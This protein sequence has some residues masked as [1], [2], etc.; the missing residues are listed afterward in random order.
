MSFHRSGRGISRQIPR[1]S[2]LANNRSICTSRPSLNKSSSNIEN[3]AN[4]TEN[5]NFKAPISDINFSEMFQVQ[6]LSKKTISIP[7]TESAALIYAVDYSKKKIWNKF[8]DFQKAEKSVHKQLP[9]RVW[10]DIFRYYFGAKDSPAQ[11]WEKYTTLIR[12]MINSGIELTAFEIALV[13][14]VAALNGRH[15]TIREFWEAFGKTK[16]NRT[17]FLWNMYMEVTCNTNPKFWRRK[18]N[19]SISKLEL[20]PPVSNDAI[21][22]VSGIIADGLT[23][24]IL[25]YENVL[26]YLGQH[27]ELDYAE[28]LLSSLWKI[29]LENSPIEDEEDS[30]SGAV[31]KNSAIY[32]RI[33]TLTAIINTYGVNDQLAKGLQIVQKMREL[34]GIELNKSNSIKFWETVLGWAFN[35]K[36]PHGSISNTTFDTLWTGITKGHNIKPSD[37]L[38]YYKAKHERSKQNFDA[39]LETIPLLSHRKAGSIFFQTV[40]SMAKHGQIPKALDTIQIY[41]ERYPYL[42]ANGRAAYLKIHRSKQ[43]DKLSSSLTQPTTVDETA[44]AQNKQETES[45]LTPFNTIALVR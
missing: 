9:R 29:K 45:N 40:I 4:N 28:G 2:N 5:S 32:P 11:T 22:L 27:G 43:I 30:F 1:I 21:K 3:E 6:P 33:Q 42:A 7:L 36:E 18:F 38:L 35:S 23:P 15:D 8:N 20:E 19:G 13:I 31:S 10:T 16:A 12:T 14:K 44:S 26:L 17:V 25:T 39:M 41:S 34:Y 24:N 37:T